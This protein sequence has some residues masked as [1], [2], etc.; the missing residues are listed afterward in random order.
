MT[1]SRERPDRA[2]MDPLETAPDWAMLAIVTLLIAGWL[3]WFAV[4]AYRLIVV[5]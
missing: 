4:A 5:T 1:D 2:A 3:S